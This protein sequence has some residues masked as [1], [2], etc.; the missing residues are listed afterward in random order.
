[1]RVWVPSGEREPPLILRAVTRPRRL[2][3]AKLL[4]GG[5]AGSRTKVKRSSW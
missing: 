4:V 3:S 2:R 5:T 1:M